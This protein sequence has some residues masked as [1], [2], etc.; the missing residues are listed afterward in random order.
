MIIQ[1]V[2]T[3]T[4]A[5]QFESATQGRVLIMDGDGPAYEVSA[6]V[7]TMPTAI[8]RYQKDVLTKMFLTNSE[9]ARV[10]LTHETS[11]KAGRYDII[12]AKPYQG[13]RTGKE[14]PSLLAPLRAAIAA[15]HNW[16]PEF[17][18]TM[19]YLLEADDGIIMDA[20][21]LG[22]HGVTMSDDKDMRCT[23]FP[24][25]ERSKGII[26]PSDPVGEL[27]VEYT[28]SGTPKCLGHSLKFFW[29]QMVMG[30]AADHIQ[31]LKKLNGKTVGP[32]GAYNLLHPIRDINEVA[33]T[34]IDKYRE[35]GQNPIPEGW[36][37]WLLRWE[38]DT[39]W[40]YLSELEFSPANRQYLDDCVN[41]QWFKKRSDDETLQ[42]D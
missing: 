5:P 31:G 21:R 12:A 34:V 6:T 7:K 1:G 29:A 3:S 41:L 37:L 11:Y 35:I 26:L 15:E 40:N 10:H 4:L 2:D 30:D 36:L 24:Y 23:P 39:F 18:V 19:H 38:G 8:S 14:K 16:L 33:N 9:S 25:Y 42:E 22:D 27:W 32:A 13:N 28:G 20:Y 17:D